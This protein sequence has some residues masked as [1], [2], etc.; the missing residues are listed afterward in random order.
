MKNSKDRIAAWAELV[1]LS[2]LPTAAGDA[3]TGVAVSGLA[4]DGW[5]T[6]LYV[7]AACCIYAGGTILNDVVDAER[8]RLTRPL[9]PVPSGKISRRTAAVAAVL[10]LVA[11]AGCG[12]IAY[13]SVRAAAVYLLLVGT[14]TLYDLFI[15][16]DGVTAAAVMAACRAGNV[17][18]PAAA[19]GTATTET[20][21]VSAVVGVYVLLLSILAGRETE[22]SGPPLRSYAL[23]VAATTVCAA[24]LARTTV[25]VLALPT[26]AVGMIAVYGYHVVKERKGGVLTGVMVRNLLLVETMTVV[27]SGAQHDAAGVLLGLRALSGLLGRRISGG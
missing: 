2:N 27:A 24:M 7:T 4:A 19:G 15:P 6:A 11:G 17:L 12:T 8:D 13:P 3:I 20:L 23:T 5:K 18:A 14:V 10:L 22:R 21:I 1:R 25:A 26:A 9:R 16:R